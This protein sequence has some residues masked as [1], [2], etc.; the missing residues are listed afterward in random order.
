LKAVLEGESGIV[1][2]VVNYYTV[3]V[4]FATLP[5]TDVYD[6]SDILSVTS[7]TLC[8]TPGMDTK[9]DIT[10][11][12]LDLHYLSSPHIVATLHSCR[13]NGISCL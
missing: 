7:Y 2:I 10:G 5:S 12:L 3:L 8:A 1:K 9:Q 11:S 4:S 6:Q 13:M